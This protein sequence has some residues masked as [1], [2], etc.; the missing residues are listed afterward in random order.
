MYSMCIQ[1]CVVHCLI[2]RKY[3]YQFG[4]YNFVE[5]RVLEHRIGPYSQ[6]DCYQCL[7][8]LYSLYKSTNE[9]RAG[10]PHNRWELC[11]A[12]CDP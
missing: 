2:Y 10:E 1:T 3:S 4:N 5:T 8:N 6:L 11:T 9:L 12:C 7:M